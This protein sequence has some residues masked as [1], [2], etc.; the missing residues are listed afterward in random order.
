MNRVFAITAASERVSIG[1]N[2]SGEITFTVT[3]S[4]ARPLRGQLRVRPI[5]STR[6]EWLSV[7]GET[8]RVFSPN[9]TQQVLVKIATPPGA[10]A[11]KYQ[12]R[13]DAISV[14]N[15]D[16]DF[17]EGPTIDLEVKATEAPKKAFPWWI[18]AAAAAGVI[19][20]V[21]LTWW[22]WPK[23]GAKVVFEDNFDEAPKKAWSQQKTET[24]P[25]G[26]AK[27]LGQF[28]TDAVQMKLNDLPTHKSVTVNFDLFVINSWQGLDPKDGC[29][30]DEWG[31][32]QGELNPSSLELGKRASPPINVLIGSALIY[33]TFSNRDAY[34]QN[35]ACG[36]AE[37][38]SS[39]C[40][41]GDEKATFGASAIDF[42]GYSTNPT[43]TI[44]DSVYKIRIAFA[45]DKS[46]LILTFF[47][48][49]KENIV[50]NRN[51]GNEGW[52]LDNVRV[53]VQ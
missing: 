2:G 28:W 14:I 51:I 25:N 15:P 23:G 42:L 26:K 24:T 10:P 47:G 9:A 21:A 32:L 30:P 48:N 13:L 20:V 45:H 1:G 6:G 50:T 27:F 19:L 22:L 8:E 36:N 29:G 5:G 39:T 49:L 46:D 4:S 44:N 12:F 34:R 35:Y 43:L 31:V 38:V 52:G 33:T 18:V 3:N 17:T 37:Y 11:G 7:A 41:F 40:Y 16:D 53:E